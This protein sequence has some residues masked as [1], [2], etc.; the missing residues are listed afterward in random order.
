MIPRL[1]RAGDFSEGSW[2]KTQATKMSKL[3]PGNNRRI[4]F[5]IYFKFMENIPKPLF[6]IDALQ[7]F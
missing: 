7:F 2:P 6:I 1:R 4:R 3:S 5:E